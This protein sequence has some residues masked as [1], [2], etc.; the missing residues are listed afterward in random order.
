MRPPTPKTTI[1][2]CVYACGSELTET[3]VSSF[4]H[5]ILKQCG[6][7]RNVKSGNYYRTA[8]FECTMIE[9]YANDTI[10]D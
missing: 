5:R 4:S 9:A 1:D 6:Y 3:S 2:H 7:K 10:E 8:N